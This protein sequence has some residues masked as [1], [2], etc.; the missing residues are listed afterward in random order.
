MPLSCVDLCPTWLAQEV[1][2]LPAANGVYSTGAQKRPI[3][4]KSQCGKT[5]RL[6]HQGSRSSETAGAAGGGFL[7]NIP[8]GE[9]SQM[10][11]GML[12]ASMTGAGF[13]QQYGELYDQATQAGGNWLSSCKLVQLR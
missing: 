1:A 9:F 10:C 8:A 7:A 12:P 2:R 6:L 5:L 13:L 4:Q 11:E 3:T